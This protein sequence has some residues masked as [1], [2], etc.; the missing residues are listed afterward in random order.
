MSFRTF[1]VLPLAVLL[2]GCPPKIGKK[3]NI[4]TDCSQLGDRLCDTNQP[5]GYC[6]IFNCE[7]DTCPESICVG[8]DPNLDPACKSADDGR[9]PSFQRTFCMKACSE[10]SDCRDG[11]ECIDLSLPQYQRSRRAEVVDI[12]A[13]DGGLGFGVCMV[14]AT[15]ASDAG[16]MSMDDSDAGIPGVCR[17]APADAGLV[18]GGAPWPPFG[19]GTGGAGG[20]GP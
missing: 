9:W 4:S 20:A 13:A 1:W 6:T 17:P 8:F 19:Q 14:K 7:P 16:V 18:D 12:G 10:D 15:S 2:L 3:C 5:D 11:Y